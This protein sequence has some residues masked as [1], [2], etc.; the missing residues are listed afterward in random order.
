MFKLELSWRQKL[1]SVNWMKSD[2]FVLQFYTIDEKDSK[3]KSGNWSEVK[4][5]KWNIFELFCKILNLILS[6]TYWLF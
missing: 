6:V 4:E 5:Q 1:L 2:V 3:M